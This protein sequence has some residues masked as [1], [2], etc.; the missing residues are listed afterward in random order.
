MRLVAPKLVHLY[1]NREL[2]PTER[3]LRMVRLHVARCFMFS[4]SDAAANRL[5]EKIDNM[6]NIV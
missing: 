3:T 5:N 6:S 1:H 2:H 4:A